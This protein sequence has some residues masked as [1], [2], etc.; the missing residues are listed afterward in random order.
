MTS[1]AMAAV[2]VS[3]WTVALFLVLL[4]LT[5]AYRRA[6]AGAVDAAAVV[7]VAIIALAVFS[8]KCSSGTLAKR[9]AAPRGRAAAKGEQKPSPTQT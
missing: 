1:L 3:V 8:Q 7:D 5:S 2:V 6:I 4:E 9:C